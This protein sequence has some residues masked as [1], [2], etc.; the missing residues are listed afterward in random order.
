LS[1]AQSEYILSHI[2]RIESMPSDDKTPKPMW[3]TFRAQPALVKRID[4]LA[5]AEKRSR[6]NWLRCRLEQLTQ[7][8][9]EDHAA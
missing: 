2:E 9:T 7:P 8:P 4:E 1:Y 5:H 3:L 6:A